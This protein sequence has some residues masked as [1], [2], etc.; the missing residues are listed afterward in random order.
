[1]TGNPQTLT[2]VARLFPLI[3]SGEKTSTIRWRETRIRPGPML[4]RC[5]TDPARTVSVVVSRCS[6]MPLSQAAAFVGRSEDWPDAVMLTGMRLHY[7]DIQLSSIVQVIEF[8]PPVVT[9]ASP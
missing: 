4:F 8:H 5:E 9:G 1:M 2:V 3:L 7:P 6:D